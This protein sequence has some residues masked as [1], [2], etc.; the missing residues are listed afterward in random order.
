MLAALL[1]YGDSLGIH[2]S[3]Q[4]ARVCEERVEAMAVTARNPL[5]RHRAAP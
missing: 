4:M 5:Q 1:R 2:A 3:R